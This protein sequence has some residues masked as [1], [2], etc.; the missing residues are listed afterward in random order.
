ML[1]PVFT[2]ISSCWEEFRGMR[3][4]ICFAS[5]QAGSGYSLKI[6]IFADLHFGD[7]AWSD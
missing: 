7:N 6:A 3:I 1:T 5:L 4:E 2:S